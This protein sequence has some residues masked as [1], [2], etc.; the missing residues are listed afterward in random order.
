MKFLQKAIK[1][2]HILSAEDFVL[3]KAINDPRLN[4]K[5]NWIGF[6][7][8]L[9]SLFSL[10]S[11]FLLTYNILDSHLKYLSYPI[12]ILFA[13]IV[14]LIYVF[15][16]Y[17]ITPPLLFDKSMVRNTKKK[18]KQS[19]ASQHFFEWLLSF[20]VLI[21]LIFILIFSL[22][23]A[24]P[25]NAFLF[26]K[27]IQDDLFILKTKNVASVILINDESTI[28]N[29]HRTYQN[30]QD[31]LALIRLNDNVENISKLEF[32]NE[33]ILS[34]TLFLF[35]SNVLLEK[36]NSDSVLNKLS[37]A[38]ELK[39]SIKNEIRSDS[40]F[41]EKLINFK[42]KIEKPSINHFTTKIKTQI[43]EKVDSHKTIFKVLN[44]NQYYIQKIKLLSK[45][46]LTWGVSLLVFLLF[47]TPIYMKF[48]LRNVKTL[49]NEYY[50]DKKEKIVNEIVKTEYKKFT[51]KYTYTLNEINKKNYVRHLT[52]I[53]EFLY[54]LKKIDEQKEKQIREEIDN[55]YNQKKFEFYNHFVDPPFNLLPKHK[56]K[57]QISSQTI[58]DSIH[59]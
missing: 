51:Q 54:Q 49:K 24:Q 41:R 57:K 30:F 14:T 11:V 19:S 46:L 32:I 59:G 18:K 35:Q 15:L 55:Y 34:D 28:I 2:L 43:D 27:S 26:E 44:S 45:S 10:V 12:S 20:S 7:V 23:I 1:P 38:Y 39:T 4:K 17:T 56:N 16:L 9:V 36:L 48:T 3:I 22:L 47:L 29:E 8:S 58:I 5:F 25:L 52:E 31:S 33:K 6:L 42:S 53:E 50:Y 40:I 21:R 37:I 13:I